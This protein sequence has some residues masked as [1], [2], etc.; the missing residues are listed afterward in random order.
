MVNSRSLSNKEIHVRNFILDN[1]MDF[2]IVTETWYKD[3]SWGMSDINTFGLK[4]KQSIER[5]E[6]PEEA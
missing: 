1:G 4:L 5:M 2:G 6:N 3:D